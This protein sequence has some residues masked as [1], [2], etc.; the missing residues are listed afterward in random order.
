MFFLEVEG[1]AL[2]GLV[3]DVGE[4]RGL[5][6]LG[7][8]LFAD[9]ALGSGSDLVRHGGVELGDLGYSPQFGRA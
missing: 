5:V 7:G 8:L 4:E 9:L 6:L 3:E 2:T 1:V